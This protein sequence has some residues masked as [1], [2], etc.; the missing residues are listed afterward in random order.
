MVA[1]NLEILLFKVSDYQQINADGFTTE[2]SSAL[3]PQRVS[4]I[5]RLLPDFLQA[6][7]RVSIL[8]QEFEG[9]T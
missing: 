5:A 6:C 4:V 3:H 8:Q 1:P 9:I 7:V 2:H